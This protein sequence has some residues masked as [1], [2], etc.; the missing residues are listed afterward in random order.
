MSGDNSQSGEIPGA[1]QQKKVLGLPYDWRRPTKARAKSR[2][3]NSEEP[4]LFPPKSFGAGWTVNFYCLA[5]LPSYFANKKN[6]P[7]NPV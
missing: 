4:R 1:E 5:H 3:W 6:G 2:M 7:S